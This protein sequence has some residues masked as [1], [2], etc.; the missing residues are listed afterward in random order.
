MFDTA[1]DLLYRAEFFINSHRDLRS[2]IERNLPDDAI[3]STDYFNAPLG[4]LSVLNANLYMFEAV[5]CVA[6]LLRDIQADSAMNEISFH[7]LGGTLSGT[8]KEGFQS[9]LS[10]IF[11]DYK[12]SGLK[13]MRDKYIDHKDATESGDPSGAFI[14]LVAEE[15]VDSCLRV[16]VALLKLHREYFPDAVANNYFS[17]YYS[18]GIHF[19]AQLLDDRTQR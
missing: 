1:L 3:E 7:G 17:D 6:S 12:H 4:K 15:F 14:N 8:A 18:A 16:I 2:A 10:A 9:R 19:H 11:A 13:K 5:S